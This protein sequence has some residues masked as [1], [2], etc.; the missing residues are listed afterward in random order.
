[1]SEQSRYSG[2]SENP[3]DISQ[4]IFKCTMLYILEA[5]LLVSLLFDVLELSQIVPSLKESAEWMCMSSVLLQS[6]LIFNIKIQQ[7]EFSGRHCGN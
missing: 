2:T 6:D 4:V 5:F 1:M 3:C 7:T